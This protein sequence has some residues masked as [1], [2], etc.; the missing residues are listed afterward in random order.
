MAILN[1]RLDDH[2]HER[3]KMMADDQGISLSEC[4]RDLLLEAV[5]PIGE[6][7]DGA[8]DRHG[9]AP[10]PETLRLMDRQMLSLLHRI[11]A[12]VLP[13]DANDDDGDRD[14]QLLMARNLESGFT[15]EYWREVA[16]FETELSRRDSR[17]LMDILQ[18]FRVIIAS[19]KHHEREGAPV[20]D[21][22][23]RRL[24][25]RG[26]DHN[27]PLEGHMARYVNHLVSTGR[28]EELKPYI[29][30]NDGGNSHMQMLDIY[31]RMLAEYRRIMDARERGVSMLDSWLLSPEELTAIEEATTH[32]SHRPK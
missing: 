11:L 17:R 29:E 13:E 18:M 32:P 28:W 12:R 31:S 19:L 15:S 5:I 16:G 2:L 23:I 7:G 21:A 6:D 26:F 10:A 8:E 24:S 4:V 25:Y 27:D 20:D 9:D 14:H 30:E 22:L 3:L 1:V